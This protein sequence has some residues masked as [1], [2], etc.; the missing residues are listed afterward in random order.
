MNLTAWRKK[1]GNM[2][3]WFP[4]QAR[5]EG[6]VLHVPLYLKG[7]YHDKRYEPETVEFIRSRLKR[8]DTFVDV[9]ANVGFYSLLASGI[10]GRD[11]RVFAIEPDERNLRF[12]NK[13]CATRRNIIVLPAAVW[14]ERTTKVLNFDVDPSRSSLL[15]AHTP[16]G[17]KP[18]ECSPLDELIEGQADLIKVDTEGVEY[19]ALSGAVRLLAAHPVIVVENNDNRVE[20][21]LRSFG[22]TGKETLDTG[23]TMV[24]FF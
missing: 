8:G 11:G 20:P 21:L 15:A 7:A 4:A 13:N 12:L 17:A 10:V 6:F 16:Q 14:N 9:G 1:L 22:Y 19:E 3:R 2:K 18:V 5:C 24:A 23:N